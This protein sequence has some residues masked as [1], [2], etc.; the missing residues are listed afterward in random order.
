[1]LLTKNDIL[2]Y[3][4]VIS[5]NDNRLHTFYKRME[6][7]NFN[8]IK[9]YIGYNNQNEYKVRLINYS[10]MS[11]V[12]YA[13]YNNYPYV[14]IFEDDAYPIKNFEYE[15]N[16][17]LNNIPNDCTVLNLGYTHGN[18]IHKKDQNIKNNSY[19]NFINLNDIYIHR[20][21]IHKCWGS[22]SYIIFKSDYDRYI[23]YLLKC[24][25]N[26]CH[27]D[28]DNC[29]LLNNNHYY[30]KKIPLFLQMMDGDNVHND[31]GMSHSLILSKLY[32]LL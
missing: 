16:I 31:E 23:N 9:H 6:S 30:V 21:D 4:Y 25:P 26:T 7:V 13:K 22:H 32:N 27:Y 1:M 5:V 3:S 18:S 12:L 15:L 8:G 14:T 24:T 2:K 11:I 20:K 29:L 10:H 19:D 17:A 28:S